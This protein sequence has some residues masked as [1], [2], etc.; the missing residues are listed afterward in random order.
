MEK[1]A[2]IF[3]IFFFFIFSCVL[4]FGLDGTIEV[5]DNTPKE[6]E[7]IPPKIKPVKPYYDC[8]TISSE[9]RRG[10][11]YRATDEKKRWVAVKSRWTEDS[12]GVCSITITWQ[13]NAFLYVDEKYK[14][15]RYGNVIEG[16]LERK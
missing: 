7:A 8:A 5:D 15:D 10:V 4:L 11:S 6:E 1:L 3:G 14:V 12:P 2:A 9:V 16:N 13:G